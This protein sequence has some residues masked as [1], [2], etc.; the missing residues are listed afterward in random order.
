MF[1]IEVPSLLRQP[2]K[3]NYAQD[4]NRQLSRTG[5]PAIL[6]PNIVP[7]CGALHK[8][9]FDRH[10]IASSLCSPAQALRDVE[11]SA[12]SV[13]SPDERSDIRDHFETAPD[14]ASLIRATSYPSSTRA[15]KDGSFAA[16]TMTRQI[17][18]R[19]RTCEHHN[20]ICTT[21]SPLSPQI[22]NAFTPHTVAPPSK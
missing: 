11:R 17:P 22:A 18:L 6:R 12:R 19:I 3:N 8:T 20:L 14:I 2:G 7:A 10:W 5:R 15:P 1:E 9:Q 21:Q 16:L 4:N 13:R